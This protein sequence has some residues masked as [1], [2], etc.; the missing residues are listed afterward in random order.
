MK[1]I[2]NL[3]LVVVFTMTG[4]VNFANNTNT[5]LDAKKVTIVFNDAK[6]GHKLTVKDNYGTIL[7][8]EN[9]TKEGKL[10]K[11]FDFSKLENGNYSLE[12]EKDFQII[13]KSIKIEGN[14]V[15]FNENSK[16][17]IFKPVIRNEDNKLMISKI[18]FD[19]KPLKVVLYYN[20]EVI[21]SETVK[22]DSIVNRVYILDKKIKGNYRVVVNNNGRS[23]SN[24]F[25]I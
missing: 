11:K 15:T 18:A 23:Y 25:K 12:L 13:I 1:T 17:V 5:L 2:K 22:G 6:K 9:V 3:I 10:I 20:N 19:K 8:S 24:E 4:F 14:N 16:K 7:H 21:Y